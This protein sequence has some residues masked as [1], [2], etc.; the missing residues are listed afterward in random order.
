MLEIFE[1]EQ[2]SPQWFEVR[3]GIPT[4]SKYATILAEGKKKGEPSVGR[5]SYMRT[6]AWEIY[7]QATAA[8]T[9]TNPN[10]D[11][12]KALEGSARAMYCY[13]YDVEARQ[14]G[15]IRESDLKT[16]VSPDALIGDDGG[17]EIKTAFPHIVVEKILADVFPPEHKP[18]C[19]GFLLVTGRKWIDL[20]IYW[21]GGEPFI[22]RAERDE[23]YIANLA[24]KIAEFNR[25]LDAM[26]AEW[27]QRHVPIK[28]QLRASVELAWTA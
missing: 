16:G 2:G 21:P 12:G 9:Y 22:K 17:L 5:A 14:V 25:D 7:N 27:R 20:V 15:F 13:A 28:E 8:E 1:C 24:S 19:Q 10:F 26:V 18:Q 3:R 23:V 11:R 4:A 6:L